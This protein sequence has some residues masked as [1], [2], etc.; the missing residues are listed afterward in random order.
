MDN[1]YLIMRS[2]YQGL[3]TNQTCATCGN[4]GDACKKCREN[5]SYYSNWKSKEESFDSRNDGTIV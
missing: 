3:A 5:K 1:L 4:S 2:R